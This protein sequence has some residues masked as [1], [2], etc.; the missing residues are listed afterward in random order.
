MVPRKSRLLCIISMCLVVIIL[1]YEYYRDAVLVLS[2]LKRANKMADELKAVAS[3]RT[4]EGEGAG[5]SAAVDLGGRLSVGDPSPQKTSSWPRPLPS[6]PLR[7]GDVS[8]TPRKHPE[9]R[10]SVLLLSSVGRSGSSFLGEVL[11]SQE[12]NMYFY[13]PLRILR[14]SQRADGALVQAE[15]RR[16]F[17]CEIPSAFLGSAKEPYKAVRHAVTKGRREVSVEEVRRRC[18]REPMR[19]VKTI[20]TR[21]EWTQELLDDEELN[22]KV[23]HLVRDPRGSTVSMAAVDWNTGVEGACSAVLRD[24]QLREEMQRKYPDKYFFVKYEEYC[25]DPY[26]K[27]REILRFLRGGG[28]QGRDQKRDQRGYLGGDQGRDQERDRRR[29]EGEDQEGPLRGYQKEDQKEG[30]GGDPRGGQS[31]DSSQTL[32]AEPRPSSA[33]EDLP[34]EVLLYL[35]SHV[36]LAPAARK[37]PWTTA[38]D[39]SAVHQQWRRRITQAKLTKAE[40]ACRDVLLRL[41]YRFFGSV[42]VARNMSLSVFDYP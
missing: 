22:L 5:D 24:L 23:I 37:T 8:Q 7:R 16:Y 30:E 39:T 20:R 14:P 1:D 29:D 10:Q 9:L 38:R 26:R 13:E 21:L 6:S 27:T 34:A 17:G 31:R 32:E 15:L 36:H 41:N 4:G 28:D 40:D 25:L 11:A 3:K 2:Y 35:D 12:R 19:I 33:S 42:D 18:G